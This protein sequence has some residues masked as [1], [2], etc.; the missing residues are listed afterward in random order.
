MGLIGGVVRNV[1]NNYPLPFVNS[2]LTG[3]LNCAGT[4]GNGIWNA[5][6][7]YEGVNVTFTAGGM[8]Q[9]SADFTSADWSYYPAYGTYGYWKVVLMTPRETTPTSCF[10]GDTQVLMADGSTRVIARI[11]VGD[12]V[13]GVDGSANTVIGVETPLL[14]DRTL[15]GFDGGRP[16]VTAE[17]PFAT[18]Q[19]WRSV[20]PWALGAEGVTLRVDTLIAGDRLRRVVGVNTVVGVGLQRLM[21]RTELQRLKTIEPH[22]ANHHTVV[23]NLILQHDHTYIANGWVVHNKGEH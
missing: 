19:G 20:D 9:T 2:C 23:Y 5:A 11:S 21:P 4:D 17:H 12:Q 22:R 13:L 7:G 1:N 8:Y 3:T 16:F 10:A 6:W 14:G 15:Y 18:E